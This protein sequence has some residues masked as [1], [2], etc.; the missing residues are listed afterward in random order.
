MNSVKENRP[1]KTPQER[2][3]H[4]PFLGSSHSWVFKQLA[5]LGKD[6]RVLDIG[7]GSGNAAI[8]LRELGVERIDAVELRETGCP[9]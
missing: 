6:A 8:F 4:K 9:P 5:E 2:Y 3:L 1:T 7:P